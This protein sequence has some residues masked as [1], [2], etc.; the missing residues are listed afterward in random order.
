[1]S[2]WKLDHFSDLS[3]L[4]AAATDIVVADFVEFFFVFAFDRFTFGVHHRRGSYDTEFGGLTGHHFEFYGFEA[5][6]DNEKVILLQRT[7]GVSK[8]RDKERL[9]NVARDAFNG[10]LH[11]E[12]VDLSK[13][14][15][16]RSAFDDHDV[17]ETA[18]QVGSDTLVHGDLAVLEL[19][20]GQG[21]TQGFF[22]FF[23]TD[24]DGV[25]FVDFQ[26]V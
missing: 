18:S 5:S 8:V 13:V 6:S 12:N 11:R 16:I 1:M 10:V 9:S 17:A 25:S 24:Q 3:H 7:V 26:F 4:F 14:G 23:A 20:V 22:A 15:N 19:V 21:D 2:Q